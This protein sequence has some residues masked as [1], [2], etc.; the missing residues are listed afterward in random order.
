MDNQMMPLCSEKIDP[1]VLLNV[2][3]LH[4]GYGNSHVLRGVD[5][6]VSSGEV[7]AILGPN[8]VGKTTLLKCCNTI[9]RP[10]R[11]KIELCGHDLKAFSL[12]EIAKHCAYVAQRSSAPH[13]TVF[14]TVL[15][16][17]KPHIRWRVR[18]R[19]LKAVDS[20]LGQLGLRDM[21]LRYVDDLSG[22]EM[23]KVAIARALVQ[24]PQ[25]LLLDEPTSALDLANQVMILRMVRQ[26]VKKHN[27]AAVMTMHD[28]NLALR[29]AD[30]LLFLKD[31]AIYDDVTS[32][33]ITSQSISKVYGLDV[34]L[35]ELGKVNVVIPSMAGG[36][37]A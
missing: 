25:V 3:G 30:R 9:L 21:Q 37:C 34:E 1:T 2:E 19:E 26:V 7:V 15:M 20:V 22:G 23:Q 17:R 35:H 29:F 5:F 31:G 8:G 16:G 32:E 6:S 33:N 27:I 4:Y 36:D 24:E 18:Q 13:L 14:D 11:G 12:R 28:I 10:S